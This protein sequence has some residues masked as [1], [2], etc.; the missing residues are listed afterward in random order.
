[1]RTNS[2]NRSVFFNF[3]IDSRYTPLF[4]AIVFAVLRCNYHMRCAIEEEDAS[5]I[6]LTKILRMIEECRFGIHDL[7]R[8]ELDPKSRLPR[9]NMPFE[10]GLFLASKHFGSEEH[11]RKVCLIFENK[12]H[13]YEKFISDLKGVDPVAHE[14]DPRTAVIRVRNWLG[15]NSGRSH[16]PGGVAIWNDYKTFLRGL[17]NQCRQQHLKPDDLTFPDYANLVYAWIENQGVRLT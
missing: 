7:S 10:L 16:L 11:K 5:E 1:M 13:S 17:P 3:P 4:R 14:N 2:Y 15:T 9:F 12:P 6:R 8:I